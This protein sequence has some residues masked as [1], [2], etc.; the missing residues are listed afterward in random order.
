MSLNFVFLSFFGIRYTAFIVLYPLGLFI[1]ESE[2]ISIYDISLFLNE[3][4]T[5]N[6]IATVV[7]FSPIPFLS[8]VIAFCINVCNWS[9][10]TFYRVV[11]LMYQ[12]LPIIKKRNL[13]AITFSGLP[14][15]YYDFVRVSFTFS[16]LSGS[17]NSLSC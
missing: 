8:T 13:Y 15:S 12:A 17:R 11:W 7:N 4:D 14:F 1:G 9:V 2:Y 10:T 5:Y 6:S 16:L 3:F